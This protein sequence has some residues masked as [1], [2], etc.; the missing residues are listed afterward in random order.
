MRFAYPPYITWSAELLLLFFKTA[1]A[2][3]LQAH[4]ITYFVQ[5]GGTIRE[6][7]NPLAIH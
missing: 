2:V 6:L 7:I 4:S 1:K 5:S 3:L